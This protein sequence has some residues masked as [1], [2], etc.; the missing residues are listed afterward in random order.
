MRISL[1][2]LS[3]LETTNVAFGPEPSHL[4][5]IYTWKIDKFSQIAKEELRSNAFEVGGHK[6]PAIRP[7]LRWPCNL[8]LGLRPTIDY[9]S[10]AGSFTSRKSVPFC[11]SS[12]YRGWL[13]FLLWF[14]LETSME[15]EIS[16]VR[17]ILFYPQGSDACSDLSLFL[18]VAN[19]DKLLPGWSHLVLFT[20]SVV[21]K[22]SKK[23][24]YSDTLQRF[25]S[26]E[27]DWGWKKFMELSRLSDGFL[28]DGT[29][30]IRAQIQVI[31]DKADHPFCC[32]DSQ[33]KRELL[34]VYLTN[35][36]QI[37]RRFEEKRR[38]KLLKLIEDKARF[39][40]FWS[41]I[42][43]HARPDISR[44][45]RNMMLEIIVNHFFIEKEVTSTLVM[46]FLY[47]G[48]KN[49]DGQ[50][51][52][53]DAEMASAPMVRVEK[54]MFLIADNV[55]LVL[56]RAALKPFPKL[57]GPQNSAYIGVTL[58]PCEFAL[59]FAAL[60][61]LLIGGSHLGILKGS[62]VSCDL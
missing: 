8:R 33:Y 20:I 9:Y 1:F 62:T 45:K 7:S 58:S 18:C 4:Y 6:C 57:K 24:K 22:D 27:H 59:L 53:L 26:K 42:D 36:E 16:L 14:V 25:W 17:S 5:G 43:Q 51:E 50:M 3:K 52:Q 32:L 35:V 37:F 40:S 28:V 19:H 31:R 12:L 48:L 47:S 39:C 15:G 38:G 55:L 29:L 23:S 21:N 10:R 2:S 11:S 30:I 60:V 56:E 41:G 46:D 34:Q 61:V 54:D 49:L 44:E 13:L